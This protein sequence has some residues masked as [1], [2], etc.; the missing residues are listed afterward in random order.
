MDVSVTMTNDVDGVCVDRIM[1]E[2][3]LPLK[4]PWIKNDC[5]T[6]E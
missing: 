3:K 1:L 4:S 5:E 2:I 6:P